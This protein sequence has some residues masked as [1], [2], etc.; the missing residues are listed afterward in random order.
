[1]ASTSVIRRELDQPYIPS[2]PDDI[3]M[4]VLARVPPRSHAVLS[5]VCRKWRD[6]VKSSALYEQRK[7]GGITIHFLCLL[8]AAPQLNPKQHPVYS[9]SVLNE[10]NNW[11]RLPPIPEYHQWGL[12]LFCRFAAVRG[13]L[14]MVGGWNPATWETL[15]S[16][17]VFN[18]SSWTWE[19]R[20]NMPST[21]SFFAC[22]AAGDSIFVAGGHDNTKMALAS[23]E[24]YDLK[25]DSWEV[26]PRMHELR[27]ECMGATLD[28][29][30]YAISG[31]HTATQCKYVKSAEVYDPASRSWSQIENMIDVSPGVIVSAFGG[32]HSLY[33]IHHREVLVYCSKANKWRAFDTLPVG[34]DGISPPLC[35]SSFGRKL[36]VTGT[37]NDDEENYRTFLYELPESTMP[38]RSKCKGVWEALPVD[39]QFLGVT[40]TSC[41][42]EL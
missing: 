14:V 34:D 38:E 17:Y 41:V 6:L 20:A 32:C 26:L 36:V 16:V 19:R 39:A 7:K 13:Q 11:E 28:G 5:G 10:H 29:K 33:A 23:A 21:R 37:C 27:D 25:S 4:E 24:R 2:L 12:P 9:V 15:R 3:A 22:A 31:Y 1:M 35:V 18:F 8:Q 40:Q 30:F 42:V